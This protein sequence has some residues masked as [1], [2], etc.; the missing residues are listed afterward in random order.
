MNTSS[1]FSTTWRG[2]SR[3]QRAAI[4][5]LL[6]A[7]IFGGCVT[8]I[9]PYERKTR[10]YMA[11]DYAAADDGR[12]AGS[13]WSDGANRLFEDQRASRVG[14][15][16]MIKVAERSDAARDASTKTKR[17]S[18]TTM[19]VS[20]FF[21]ALAK[22]ARK[23]PGLNT[24]EIFKAASAAEFEGKGTTSR[25]GKLE[26]IIPVRVRRI[27]PNGD[28]YLEGNKVILVNDEETFLYISG[29]VRPIDISPDNSVPSS[30]LADVELEYTGR[31][32][33]SERQSPGWL[34]R[35]IDVVWPF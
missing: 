33:I 7:T 20:G 23:N 18:T 31:G 27:L 14:D 11:D 21:G 35:A 32:V 19:G 16:I 25:S 2:G 17:D 12:S 6:A 9:K 29:V 1:W 28:L 24:D 4:V 5:G 30:R 3:R 34:A 22:I 8:H 10:R 15:I 13:L 26:A